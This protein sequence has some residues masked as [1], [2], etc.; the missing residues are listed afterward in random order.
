[1]AVSGTN[2]PVAHHAE[3]AFPYL[4]LS[5]PHGEDVG[6]GLWEDGLRLNVGLDRV[7]YCYMCEV[8]LVVALALL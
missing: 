4:M 1:V 7:V 3:Q 6:V 8:S 5:I 2:V